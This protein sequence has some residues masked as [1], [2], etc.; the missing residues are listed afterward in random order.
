MFTK[1]K[2]TVSGLPLRNWNRFRQKAQSRPAIGNLRKNPLSWPSFKY[3]M[4]SA[5]L[6]ASTN[7]QAFITSKFGRRAGQSVLADFG[8]GRE[9][10]LQGVKDQIKKKTLR[11]S[12]GLFM[13]A[14]P[15]VGT[16]AIGY[17]GYQEGGIT[18]A[19]GGLAVNAGFSAGLGG[20]M[21]RNTI[22][23][24]PVGVEGV[25]DSMGVFRGGRGGQ[26]WDKANPTQRL[27]SLTRGN[28]AQRTALARQI[29][30]GRTAISMGG[31]LAIGGL[32][33][34]APIYASYKALSMGR[35][36]M[37]AARRLEMG[38]PIVDVFGTQATMRQRSLQAIQRSAI[39]GRSALGMEAQL[40]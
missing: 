1:R 10:L 22:S 5:G 9:G 6:V 13:K 29:L 8:L 35:D 37:K 36:K 12:G 17:L 24:A 38:T 19:A 34:A 11:G 14:L 32:I 15:I 4:P 20:M 18:G 16:A 2:Q 30:A 3:G 21:G 31:A 33:G 26:W 25:K 40:M 7:A 39:S 27:V 28:P 23:A